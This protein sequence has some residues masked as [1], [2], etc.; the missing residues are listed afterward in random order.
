MNSD[1]LKEESILEIKVIVLVFSEDKNQL[2]A[3]TSGRNLI[4]K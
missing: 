4:S 3:L 2:R 1:P